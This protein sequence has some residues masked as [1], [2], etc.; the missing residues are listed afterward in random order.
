[1]ICNFFL[2]IIKNIKIIDS[3]LE[4]KFILSPVIKTEEEKIT[5]INRLKN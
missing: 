5:N 4:I 3:K 2:L 1:M